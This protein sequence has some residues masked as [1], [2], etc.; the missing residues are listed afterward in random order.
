[1]LSWSLD[2]VIKTKIC[3]PFFLHSSALLFPLLLIFFNHLYSFL[4][5]FPLPSLPLFFSLPSS[6]FLLCLCLCLVVLPFLLLLS[7]LCSCSNHLFSSVLCRLLRPI[8]L[9]TCYLSSN[10]DRF[11]LPSSSSTS[12]PFSSLFSLPST[13][14]AWTAN[15]SHLRQPHFMCGPTALALFLPLSLLLFHVKVL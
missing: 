9:P 12:P 1:M 11:C 6:S 8:D 14:V 15:I 2:V 10:H 7:D 4:F 13:P 3:F 5:F